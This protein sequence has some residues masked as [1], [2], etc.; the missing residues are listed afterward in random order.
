MCSDPVSA[1]VSSCVE[2][3]QNQPQY[4]HSKFTQRTQSYTCCYKE[5]YNTDTVLNI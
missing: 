3:K 5:K 2:H 4:M 1:I